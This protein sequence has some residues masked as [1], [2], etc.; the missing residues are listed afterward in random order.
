MCAVL[1][2]RKTINWNLTKT[3]SYFKSLQFLTSVLIYSSNI[4]VKIS[5]VRWLHVDIFYKSTVFVRYGYQ[6]ES[7]K[8]VRSKFCEARFCDMLKRLH[9]SVPSAVVYQDLHI[10]IWTYYERYAKRLLF[11]TKYVV[12]PYA[13]KTRSVEGDSCHMSPDL[14]TIHVAAFGYFPLSVEVPTFSAMRSTFN[15][16]NMRCGCHRYPPR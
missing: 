10:Y 5:I 8:V 14:Q 4:W 1:I 9:T 2:A 6:S 11:S 12:H 16:A 3:F 7:V 13:D 15:C